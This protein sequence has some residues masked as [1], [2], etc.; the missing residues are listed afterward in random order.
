MLGVL[1]AI[2]AVCGILIG[3]LG[4]PMIYRGLFGG[5]LDSDDH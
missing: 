4:H 2:G 1:L 3:A 5:P